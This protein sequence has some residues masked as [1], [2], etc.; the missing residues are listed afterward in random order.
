MTQISF[1]IGGRPRSRLGRAWGGDGRERITR[2]AFTLIELLVVIAIL[3]VLAGLFFPGLGRALE[4][5]RV[6]K[7]HAELANLG[8]ALEM[9]GEDHGGRFPP[10]R[11]N[12]NS[13]LMTHWAELPEELAVMGYVPRG[14][15]P[16]MSARMEDVFN[17]GHTYKYLAPGPMLLNGSWGG[18]QRVWVPD[19]FPISRSETGRYHSCPE[20]APVRWVIWSMGPR[21]ESA[22]SMSSYAPIS[23][24]TWYRRTGDSGVLVRFGT[25]DGMQ[26]KSP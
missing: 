17:R 13:D 9:Y 16:G 24:K 23:T 26:F 1:H 3:L 8:L 14:E 20:T 6:T 18:H 21:P 11:V 5:A 19:D 7:V 25:R 15:Q 4:R 12:C 22:K 10:T 2:R